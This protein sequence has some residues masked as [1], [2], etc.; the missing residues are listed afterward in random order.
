MPGWP[1][2]ATDGERIVS[3]IAS[4]TASLKSEYVAWRAGINAANAITGLRTAA[5]YQ[6]MASYRTFMVAAVGA[7][8]SLIAAAYIRRNPALTGFDP[9]ARWAELL[10]AIDAFLDWFAASWP[11]VTASGKP[12]FQQRDAVTKELLDLSIALTAGPKATLL[13]RLD[14]II[15]AL[16]AR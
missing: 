15:A 11:E 14:A 13:A 1:D 8:A 7:N 12:A 16:P 9:A 10:T 3:D 5:N 6:M 2:L 4:R